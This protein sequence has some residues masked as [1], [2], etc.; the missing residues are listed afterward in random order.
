MTGFLQLAKAEENITVIIMDDRTTAM[1]GGQVT[2]TT[3]NYV[4]ENGYS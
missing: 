1:T 2:P 3:G 4:K